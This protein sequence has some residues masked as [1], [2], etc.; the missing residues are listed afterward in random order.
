MGDCSPDHGLLANQD[1]ASRVY[2]VTG[3][4]SAE[5]H[6]IHDRWPRLVAF[7]KEMNAV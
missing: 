1:D 3:D 6:W 5:Y 2:V 4:T 7:N